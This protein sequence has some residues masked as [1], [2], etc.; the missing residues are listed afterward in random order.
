[1]RNIVLSLACAA[2]LVSVAAPASARDRGNEPAY[3]A[4]GQCVYI[5]GDKCARLKVCG[6]ASANHQRTRHC[7]TDGTQPYQGSRRDRARQF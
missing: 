2:A 1:M 3:L 5:R 4:F 6:A 7:E